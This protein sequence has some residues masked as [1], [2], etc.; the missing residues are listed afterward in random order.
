M[1]R[2]LA[3]TST[4]SSSTTTYWPC[5][6][7]RCLS[8]C[9]LVDVELIPGNPKFISLYFAYGNSRKNCKEEE[10]ESLLQWMVFFF[11]SP[12]TTLWHRVLIYK[13]VQRRRRTTMARRHPEMLLFD[14]IAF[15]RCSSIHRV[16]K[17]RAAAGADRWLWIRICEKQEQP[18]GERVAVVCCSCVLCP[19]ITPRT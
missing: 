13:S 12:A 11:F 4:S 7:C 18:A 19:F 2:M 1:D 10:S 17:C 16:H 15:Q 5:C 3:G 9:P 14:E 6:Y 8:P